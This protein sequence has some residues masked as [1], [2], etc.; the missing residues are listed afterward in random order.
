MR[1]ILPTETFPLL[2]AV[3]LAGACGPAA[4]VPHSGHPVAATVLEEVGDQYADLGRIADSITAETNRGHGAS[5]EAAQVAARN[6]AG[7]IGRVR[8][9]FEAVTLAM[10]AEQLQRVRSLWMRLAFTEAAMDMLH[11]EAS[12]LAADPLATAEELYA[13]SV[14]LAGSVELGRVSSRVAARQVLPA[15]RLSSTR[16][17]AAGAAPYPPRTSPLQ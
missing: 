13:L 10:S 16:S 1:S 4:R 7:R 2:L 6:L 15:A 9:S 3:F 5:G 17:S 11:E 14:Q 8:G 12:R